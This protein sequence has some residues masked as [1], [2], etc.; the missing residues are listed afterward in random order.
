LIVANDSDKYRYYI[1]SNTGRIAKTFNNTNYDISSTGVNTPISYHLTTGQIFLD[2]NPYTMKALK[3][4]ILFF[5][6]TGSYNIVINISVDNHPINPENSLAFNDTSGLDLVGSTFITGQSI[7][8]Y[9]VDMGPY[10]RFIDGIGHSIQIDI[11]QTQTNAAV[12]IQGFAVEYE[13][14]GYTAEIFNS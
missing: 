4:F 9:A 8:G 10:T 7:V 1:G 14:A 6:P 3:R 11:V 13:D 2:D 12:E 5:R